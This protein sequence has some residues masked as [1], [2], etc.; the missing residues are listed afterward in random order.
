MGRIAIIGA[1][2]MG[3]A[4]Y[5]GLVS[6]VGDENLAVCDKHPEKLAALRAGGMFTDPNSALEGVDTV[7]IAVKPQG[8]PELADQITVPMGNTLVISLMAGIPLA[9][10]KSSMESG[11]VIRAMPNLAAS[12]SRSVTAWVG[13]DGTS[14]EQRDRA[15][16]IFRAVGKDIELREERMLDAFTALAGSGP[17]YYFRMCEILQKKAQSMGFSPEDALTI[18]KETLIGSALVLA[19]NADPASLV[20]AVASKGGTT[21]A[22][23]K[24]FADADLEG[25]VSRA[26]DAAAKRSTE[27]SKS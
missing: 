4:F 22:A 16:A 23:L 14:S 21:E 17:A 5:R 27:L 11:A 18:A 7:I 1:G 20:T 9:K 3:S 15:R 19:G 2:K 26:V 13:A 24:I 12:V 6:E 8:F 25:L 10:L